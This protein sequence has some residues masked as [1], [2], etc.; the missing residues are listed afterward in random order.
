M[1]RGTLFFGI[2]AMAVMVVGAVALA[3]EKPGAPREL[4]GLPLLYEANFAVDAAR[5]TPTDPKAWKVTEEDGT[6]V[7]A[8]SGS[9]DYEPKVRSPKNI[10]LLNDIEVTDFILEAKIKQTGREYGHRDGCVFFGYEGPSHFYYAHIATKADEHAN[11]IF[12]VNDAPRVSIAKERTDG[13]DWG[14]TY[15]TVRIVRKA[16]SG[17]IQVFF[18]NMDKPI[19]TAEDK[20]FLAGKVGFGSF[21]DTANFKDVRLWGKKKQ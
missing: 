2:A 12:L 21:D 9:S 15:H 7:Y 4:Q 19:M 1:T 14:T 11:S 17:S 5:W 18:D 13:T 20:T 16:E 10:S 6:H 3:A 8:L